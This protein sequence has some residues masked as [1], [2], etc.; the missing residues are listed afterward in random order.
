MTTP[1]RPIDCGLHDGLLALA[2]RGTRIRLR[3]RGDAGGR[4]EM[5]GK[6]VDVFTRDGAEWLRMQGV[7]GHPPG[8]VDAGGEVGGARPRGEARGDTLEVRLDRV[9]QAGDLRLA[10]DGLLRAMTPG[11]WP[12]VA[13]ILAEGI[14]TGHATFET[15]LP[16]WERWDRGH[17]EVGRWVVEGAGGGTLAGWAALSPVSGRC[18]YAGVAEVSV[19]VGAGARG[20]GVG[21]TLLQALVASSE[22]AGIWTLQAGIFPENRASLALHRRAGFRE[23]GRRER[24]GALHGAWRDVLL[25]ERRS[26]VVGR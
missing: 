24:I 9:I 3:Y 13:R 12:Q 18:V 8:G 20:Q 1:Y 4:E 11:D 19:Y 16:A 7:P 25:L 10:P 22:E 17:L 26:P 21:T 23:V 6:I 14:A 2:T 5:E 15:E